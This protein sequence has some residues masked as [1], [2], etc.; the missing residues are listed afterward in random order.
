M[1]ITMEQVE[2]IMEKY[3]KKLFDDVVFEKNSDIETQVRGMVKQFSDHVIPLIN[4]VTG[5]EKEVILDSINKYVYNYDNS[6]H[7]LLRLTV[8]DDEIEITLSGKY[9]PDDEKPFISFGMSPH[10]NEGGLFVI[11]PFMP[12]IVYFIK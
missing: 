5:N 1:R 12:M 4:E 6:E 10:V 7:Y 11:Q 3:D 8:K 2:V 9:I